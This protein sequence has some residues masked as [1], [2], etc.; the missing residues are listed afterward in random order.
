MDKFSIA[1]CIS[2][3]QSISGSLL[4]TLRQQD[5]TISTN[6]CSLMPSISILIFSF[7]SFKNTTSVSQRVVRPVPIFNKGISASLAPGTNLSLFIKRNS[8]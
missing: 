8:C 5:F 4:I 6:Y 1:R 2:L 7:G 3:E